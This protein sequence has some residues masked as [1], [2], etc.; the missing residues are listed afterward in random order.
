MNQYGKSMSS[1][2]SSEEERN[3][4]PQFCTHLGSKQFG[5]RALSLECSRKTW[6]RQSTVGMDSPAAQHSAMRQGTAK[7]SWITARGR[8]KTRGGMRASAADNLTER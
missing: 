2:Q 6:R 5:N 1:D 8:P 3:F 4:K 7:G